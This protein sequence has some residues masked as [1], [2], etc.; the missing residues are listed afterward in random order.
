MVDCCLFAVSV[1]NLT[2]FILVR[3][4]TAAA[5]VVDISFHGNRM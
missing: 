3:L 5:S 1:Y 4:T 2:T